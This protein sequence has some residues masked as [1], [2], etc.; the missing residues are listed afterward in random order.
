MSGSVHGSLVAAWIAMTAAILLCVFSSGAFSQS[1]SSDV[2]TAKRK[3][4]AT[5]T[6]TDPSHNPKFAGCKKQA[7]AQRLHFDA[8]KR[9]MHD[10]LRT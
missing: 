2:E 3:P 10:C 1:P 4:T 5:L 7:N 9:F 8:R 6:W